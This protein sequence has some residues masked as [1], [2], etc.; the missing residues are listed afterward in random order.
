MVWQYDQ[1]VDK[2][3]VTQSGYFR[4]ANTEAFGMVIIDGDIL[5]CYVISV[6]IEDNTFSTR[7]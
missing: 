7:E 3:W 5:L 4:L 2:Y 6:V 1:A